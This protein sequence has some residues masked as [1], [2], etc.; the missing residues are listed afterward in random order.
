MRVIIIYIVVRVYGSVGASIN[1]F[2]V[3]IVS[4]L[5]KI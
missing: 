3:K 1:H 4:V 2:G 5:I